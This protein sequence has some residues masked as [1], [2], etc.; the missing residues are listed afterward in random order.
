MRK[1]LQMNKQFFSFVFFV[2]TGIFS[3]ILFSCEKLELHRISKIA[4]ERIEIE[5]TT[6]SVHGKIVDISAQGIQEYGVCWAL[7]TNPT[8]ADNI[9]NSN[10]VGDIGLFSMKIRNIV[11]YKTFY[12]RTF[13][14]EGNVV[15]YG[16][17]LFFNLSSLSGF[18]AETNEIHVLTTSS[19]QVGG[20]LKGVG[21]LVVEE[22]GH[23]W[24][25]HNPPD[26][27]HA[28]S[29]YSNLQNDTVFQSIAG[30]LPLS[31]TFFIR[32]YARIEGGIIV[33]GNTE[34]FVIPDFI[35]QTLSYEVLSEQTVKLNGNLL[36]L[37]VNSIQNHGFCWS[38]SNAS[39]SYNDNVISL[40]AKNDVGTFQSEL[41]ETQTGVIY[42]FRAFATDG[43]H[44]R[45]GETFQF[46]M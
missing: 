38:S 36:Q 17:E 4:T 16:N 7:H 26:V 35:V 30:N 11:P 28:R 43:V 39:P 12:V 22:Y 8:V 37:G 44:I 29:M 24:S 20:R 41:S 46:Q 33:Y 5:E 10:N 31:K 32:T 13:M 18:S 45:Y 3:V 25:E 1:H 9:I 42:Y 2:L 27:S 34:S 6:V 14:K 15:M 21:S 23:C 40:G 19:I